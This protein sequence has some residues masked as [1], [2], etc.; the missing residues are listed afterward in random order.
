MLLCGGWFIN[1][2]ANVLEKIGVHLEWQFICFQVSLSC[3]ISL[4][5]QVSLDATNLS[6]IL[7]LRVGAGRE[8]FKLCRL[9]KSCWGFSLQNVLRLISVGHL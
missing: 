6:H 9:L 4:N 1:L 8:T 7:Q 5:L 2:H 3:H